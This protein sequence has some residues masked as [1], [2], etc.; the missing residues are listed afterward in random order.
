M[1]HYDVK[2][3][4]IKGESNELADALSSILPDTAE[5][6]DIPNMIPF[7]GPVARIDHVV[8][9]TI[10]LSRDLIEMGE[11]GEVDPEYQGLINDIK[12]GIKM[13]ELPDDHIMKHFVRK[14]KR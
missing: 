2:L 12:N 11:V 9:K 6:A 3:K 4:Y 8:R 10:R 13:E 14:K 5:V 1:C 7:K